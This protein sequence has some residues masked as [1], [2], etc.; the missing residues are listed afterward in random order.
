MNLKCY[1]PGKGWKDNWT[2]FVFANVCMLLRSSVPSGQEYGTS[3]PCRFQPLYKQNFVINNHF[4]S[5]YSE[6]CIFRDAKINELNKS[7]KGETLTH[8]RDLVVDALDRLLLKKLTFS[9]HI[10][11]C[12]KHPYYQMVSLQNNNWGDKF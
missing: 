10:Y 4:L 6:R 11:N 12:H 3:S 5:I 1:L 9:C 8:G 7:I 2:V